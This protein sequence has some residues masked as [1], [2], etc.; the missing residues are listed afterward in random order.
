MW[1]LKTIWSK[2]IRYEIGS[3]VDLIAFS[4]LWYGLLNSIFV[5]LMTYNTTV[6]PWVRQ[7]WPDFNLFWFIG[8]ILV[9]VVI[10]LCL[11]KF[12]IYPAR[13]SFRNRWE[14]EHESPIKRDLDKQAADIKLIKEKLGINE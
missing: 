3:L 1:K 5:A 14:Y 7:Y 8:F 12:I 13:Q 9:I 4:L 10:I 11:E 6:G 2:K